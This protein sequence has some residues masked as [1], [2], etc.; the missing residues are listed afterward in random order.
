MGSQGG[1]EFDSIHQDS[2]EKGRDGSGVKRG[3]A[4]RKC[5]GWGGKHISHRPAGGELSLFLRFSSDRCFQGRGGSG[6]TRGRG[7]HVRAWR[8][9]IGE[10]R[11]GRIDQSANDFRGR[12]RGGLQG[13]MVIE[14]PAGEHR[15]GSFL[16][17]LIDQ[18]G[19]FLAEIRGV[20]QS[21]Q[22][23]TLQRGARGRLQIVERGSGPRDGH[24]Q[25]SNL[26]GW[27]ERAG[28]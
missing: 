21:G 8:L 20:I 24:G 12:Q 9:G 11:G 1:L 19:N 28:Q 14:H 22:L 3:G 23:K 4:R 26:K 27:A 13:F 7:N 17:P 15:F 2:R 16:D 25:S 10:Q 5:A 18:S 6:K